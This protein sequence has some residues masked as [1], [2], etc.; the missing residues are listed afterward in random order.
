MPYNNR[1]TDLAVEARELSVGKN[2]EIEGVEY[3]KERKDGCSIHFLEVLN[4]KGAQN[5]GKPV[6]KYCTVEIAELVRRESESFDGTVSVVAKEIAGML[7]K[8][9]GG[10]TLIVGLGN[11]EI[12]PDAIGPYAADHTIVTRHLKEHLPEDFEAFSPVAVICPGVLGTSG[13]ESASYIKSICDSLK[14]ESVIVVD[15]LAARSLDRLCKTVQ[16]TDTGITP[17]SGVGNSRSQINSETLG[18]PVVAVGIPT[19]VD[20]ATIIADMNGPAPEEK[21][22]GMIVTP[23]T[24]DMEAKSAGRLVGYAINLAL[25]EGLSIE[26]V[27][28]LIG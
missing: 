24:I 7:P 20:M 26:D 17:G 22:K 28:M 13:I 21:H 11:R 16:I 19:V 8:S 23:R 14:P 3:H 6:G 27:D 10:C 9:G 12:T 4:D 18:V 25:H 5:I 1:R 15:A 2:E